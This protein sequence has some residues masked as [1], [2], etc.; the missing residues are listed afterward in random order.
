M[1]YAWHN[2]A[3]LGLLSAL[4]AWTMAVVV[5]RSGAQRAPNRRLTL[6]FFIE[7]VLAFAG[8]I[9]TLATDAATAY[10]WAPASAALIP[11]VALAYLAFVGRLDTPLAR[12]FRPVAS[13]VAIHL[14]GALLVVLAFVRPRMFVPGV[15]RI[16]YGVWG[17]SD[18]GG[19]G[20]IL[21]FLVGFSLLV[22]LYAMVASLHALRRAPKGSAHAQRA[23][24]YAWA[25]GLRDVLFLGGYLGML[26]FGEGAGEALFYAWVHPF[27]T[28]LPVLAIGY[29]ILKTQLFDIDLKVKWGAARGSVATAMVFLVLA[30]FKVAEFYLSREIGILLGGLAA[31]LVLVLAP[32]L[33][34][35]A[36]R[37]ADKAAPKVAPTSEYLTY[38]KFEV[39]RS[40]VE[41]ALEDGE[42]SGGE[43]TMLT[44]L[45]EKM[46]IPAADAVEVESEVRAAR[47]PRSS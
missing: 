9:S 4:V 15:E 32:R 36:D 41:A 31:G 16:P 1:G 43:R 23:K 28:I 12:P 42:I 33:N 30:S 40:A 11:W 22:P 27:V 35:M 26:T 18:V 3:T 44:R 5:Y 17:W 38:R 46:A 37:V 8:S 34:R 47:A 29:A 13:A 21:L 2:F 24:A 25:F 14:L 20:D 7:G 19:G 39:Y 10:S 6:V 45:Q